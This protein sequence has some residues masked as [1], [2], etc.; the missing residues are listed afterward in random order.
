MAIATNNIVDTLVEDLK[1]KIKLYCDRRDLQY[2]SKVIE[3]SIQAHIGQLRLSGE[4]YIIHPLSVGVILA[5]L[6]QDMPTIA[7]GLLHDVVEDTGLSNRDLSSQFSEEVADLVNGVT[8]IS[9][10]KGISFEMNIAANIRK[11]LL[12]TTKDARVM[13][14]KLADKYLDESKGERNQYIEKVIKKITPQIKKNKIPG[15]VTGRAKNFYS[16]YQKMQKHQKPIQEIYDLRGVRVITDTVTDC[17]SVLGAIHSLWKPIPGRFKDYVAVP[18]INMYQSLH[19]TVLNTDGKPLEVQIRTWQMHKT[20]EE[21][22]AAHWI[23]KSKGKKI[24]KNPNLYWLN[25]IEIEQQDF[26][27][28]Q[29]F[30][31]HLRQDLINDDIYVFTP[32]GEIIHLPRGATVLDFAFKIHTDIGLN[33]VGAKIDGKMVP[34]RSLVVSGDQIEIIS[35]A[36][37]GPSPTWLRIVKTTLARNRIR[38][39]LKKKDEEALKQFSQKAEIKAEEIKK[40]ENLSAIYHSVKE[41]TPELKKIDDKKIKKHPIEVAGMNNVKVL[42]AKCCM[43]IRGD[44]ILGYITKN[45]GVSI[46]RSDCKQLPIFGKNDDRL[47]SVRWRGYEGTFPVVLEVKAEDKQGILLEIVKSISG[48][49]INIT[50]TAVKIVAGKVIARFTIDIDH[51]DSLNEIMDNFNKIDGIEGIARVI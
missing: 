49:N 9:R 2:I 7:A 12:A 15:K 10:L 1:K 25:K 39:F 37:S 6:N 13:I 29:E 11:M 20:A 34:I 26:R 31:E 51:I 41:V 36:G 43:P 46:H 4:P 48:I 27:E 35:K 33:C 30:M 18:K 38:N 40:K 16:I 42:L 23:Y 21:G 22:I 50:E 14:I 5:E 28:P 47:I 17:Y 8:K 45:R 3:F 44:S 19:T 32:K 24:Q